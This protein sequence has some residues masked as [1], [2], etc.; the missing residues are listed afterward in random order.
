MSLQ[1]ISG[2]TN[3]EDISITNGERGNL[4]LRIVY[5]HDRT[6]MEDGVGYVR[7]RFGSACA[8]RHETREA[9]GFEQLDFSH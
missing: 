3:R 6:A 5:R 8:H 2:I 9:K 4:R 1:D 7:G